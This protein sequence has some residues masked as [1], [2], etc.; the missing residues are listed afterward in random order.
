MKIAHLIIAITLSIF[1]FTILDERVE[2]SKKD[3]EIA[4]QAHVFMKTN[5]QTFI[6]AD[7]LQLSQMTFQPEQAW[8]NLKRNVFLS[9]LL[10]MAALGF[11]IES[12]RTVRKA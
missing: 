3:Y 4:V 9:G 11:L 6:D 12:F 2:N 8:K 10:T 1:N 7:I 5:H